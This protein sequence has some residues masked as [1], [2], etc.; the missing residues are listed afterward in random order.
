MKKVVAVQASK[1]RKLGFKIQTSSRKYHLT[2]DTDIA[3]QEWLHVLQASMFRAKNEADD[4][5]VSD[6]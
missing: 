6:E 1:T 5:R 4:V 2:A 3:A